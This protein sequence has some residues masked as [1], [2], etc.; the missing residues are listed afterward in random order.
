MAKNQKLPTRLQASACSLY[1]NGGKSYPQLSTKYGG[2]K[3]TFFNF[4]P[5]YIP[6]FPVE[7]VFVI[8][9]AAPLKFPLLLLLFQQRMI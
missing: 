1:N 4:R 8:L 3:I 7:P 2:T 5:R 6:T 9:T